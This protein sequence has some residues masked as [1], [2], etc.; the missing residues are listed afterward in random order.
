MDDRNCVGGGEL[1]GSRG[2]FL[3]GPAAIT[4]EHQGGG[5]PDVDV[6]YHAGDYGFAIYERLTPEI[7][8]G[9]KL[10]VSKGA[11]WLP[12]A[13]TSLADGGASAIFGRR[14]ALSCAIALQR[15]TTSNPRC[16]LS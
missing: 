15:R 11:F 6:G 14:T 1:F 3:E 9:R 12:D 5:A 4:P 10:S 13:K 8:F 2:A 16:H 7:S